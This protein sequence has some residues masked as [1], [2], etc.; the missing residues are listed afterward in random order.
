MPPVQSVTRSHCEGTISRE[1]PRRPTGLTVSV[2]G[3]K[4]VIIACPHC[5]KVLGVATKP[6]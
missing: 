4:S 5:N 6:E 2:N 3:V 1:E